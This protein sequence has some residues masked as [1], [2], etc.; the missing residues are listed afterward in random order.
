MLGMIEVE[1]PLGIIVNQPRGCPE[2]AREGIGNL[3][4]GHA[5]LGQL[6]P[7][8]HQF[9]QDRLLEAAVVARQDIR[10][11][12]CEADLVDIPSR[13]VDPS[14][15]AIRRRGGLG[16]TLLLRRIASRPRA[17]AGRRHRLGS[18]EGELNHGVDRAR[19]LGHH[20]PPLH[21]DHGGHGLPGLVLADLLDL[22]FQCIVLL[23]GRHAEKAPGSSATDRPGVSLAGRL[24]GKD[25][26]QERQVRLLRDRLVL[27]VR[28][29]ALLL[30][31]HAVLQNLN[32]R[33][34]ASLEAIVDRQIL[35]QLCPEGADI[36]RRPEV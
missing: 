15:L 31:E 9:T 34:R 26:R 28:E 24:P 4:G 5:G 10:Q 30:T 6:S 33:R 20:A 12:M 16:R 27:L 22:G 35:E 7:F 11:H 25:R 3:D 1:S 14:C 13:I 19:A 17:I 32:I 2:Q 18:H 29:H 36:H 21:V 23:R 8:E